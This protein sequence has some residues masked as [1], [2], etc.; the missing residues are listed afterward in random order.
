MNDANLAASEWVQSRAADQLE[1]TLDWIDRFEPG[2]RAAHQ[3]RAFDAWTAAHPGERPDTSR[4]SEERRQAWDDL[5][6]LKSIGA[7]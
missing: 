7:P 5:Q 2:I 4:W 1:S 6:T 3:V